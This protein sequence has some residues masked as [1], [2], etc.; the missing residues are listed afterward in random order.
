MCSAFSN[1]CVAPCCVSQVCFS[2]LSMLHSLNSHSY[3]AVLL[4]PSVRSATEPGKHQY[5]I[6]IAEMRHYWLYNGQCL[7]LHNA[8]LAVIVQS[9]FRIIG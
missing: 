4:V 9:V 3:A 6:S 8:R 7:L 1:R 2:L 5:I